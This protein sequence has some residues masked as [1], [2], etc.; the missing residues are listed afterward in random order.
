MKIYIAGRG[1]LVGSAI[2]ELALTR[3]LEVY[4]KSSQELDFRNRIATEQELSNVKP[5]IL[6]IA[7]ARVGGILANFNSPV[8]YLSDNLQIQT[9]LIDSA[10]KAE[11]PKVFFLGSSCVYPKLARQPIREKDLLTGELEVTNESYAIAKISGIKLI[12]A[13]NRQH[14]LQW[15][16]LMPTNLFGPHDNFD[17][18][19]SHVIPG[20]MARMHA[21][22]KAGDKYFEI[23]G[24]GSPLREFMFS[25]DLADAFFAILSS[26][27]DESLINIGS[28]IEISILDLANLI[29]KTIGFEGEIVLDRSKP[30]G[31]PRKLLDNSI[32]NS[33][34]WHPKYDFNLGIK[35][36]YEW[37]LL[38]I[39]NRGK[40][41]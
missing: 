23:W 30:N 9:N 36:A 39:E 11:I 24:D 18:Q 29:A 5:D 31:T 40:H 22:K 12:E 8:E 6:I 32:L 35:L 15:K 33:I 13:Y 19:T 41:A 28:G 20:V 38:N 1:G 14:G 26:N 4:G 37:Y 2:E 17:T 27:V 10:F 7:A 25:L 34:G 21:A 3:N 16:S